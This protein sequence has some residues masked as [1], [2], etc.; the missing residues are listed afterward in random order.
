VNAEEQ[1][2]QAKQTQAYGEIV[3][4][5]RRRGLGFSG[6]PLG[7]QA[8]Y[9]ST[10]YMPALA[11]LKQ[12]ARDNAMSLEEAILGINERRTTQAQSMFENERT[13]AE[14]QRQFN[15]SL[16]EQRRQSAAAAK[17][18]SSFAPSL[19]GGM[20]PGAGAPAKNDVTAPTLN[21][22]RSL[23]NAH[24]AVQQLMQTN[25]PALIAKTYQAIYQSAVRGNNYDQAK[26]QLLQQ[27]HGQTLQKS[28]IGMS[29]NGGSLRF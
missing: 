2:L 10:E 9:N 11:R 16:E 1:G 14:Q 25:N 13:F 7:E 17:A 21:G 4:G 3:D 19:G 29:N 27:L 20:K 24:D 23:Q 6:I 22:G 5:A 28:G 12:S 8:K 26:L 15:A 18:A